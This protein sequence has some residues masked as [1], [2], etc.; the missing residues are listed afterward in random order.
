MKGAVLETNTVMWGEEQM[1]SA[2]HVFVVSAD[3]IATK[4]G[5]NIRGPS[6]SDSA[7]RIVRTAL[8]S[9]IWNR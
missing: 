5:L 1:F 8:G 6:P 4:I 3:P 7:N 2:S 9:P